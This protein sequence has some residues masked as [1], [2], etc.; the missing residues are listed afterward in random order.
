[1]DSDTQLPLESARRLI[2]TI[3]HP[4]NRVEID[5]VS[6]VRTSG[7]TII[8]PRISIALPA[9]TATRFTRIFADANGTDPYCEAVSDAQQE[10]LSEGIFHGKAIYDVKAFH[11]ILK[12]RFPAETILS[13]DLIEGAHAGVGL[14][15]DIELFENMP[16]DYG[17]FAARERRWIRGD[18]QIAPWMFGNVPLSGGKKCRTPLS[19][20][21]RWRILDNLRR[22]LI[23]VA[24]VGLLL[25]GWLMSSAPAVGSLVV[26]LAV[27][28][29]AFAPLLDRLARRLHGSVRGWHGAADDVRRAAVMIAFLPH[30]AW[31]AID[32]IAR[33]CYRRWFSH[34]KMLEWQT[35]ERVQTLGRQHLDA[36]FRQLLG[37]SILSMVLAVVLMRYGV[38][39]PA[40]LFVGLWIF[41][42]LL[43]NWLASPGQ[44]EPERLPEND[45]WFLRRTAR[46]TWRYF[47][48]PVG[49]ETNWLP[50]DNSQVKYRV[51][52]APRT[53]P[54]NI[55]LWFVAALTAWDFGYLTTDEMIS[56]CAQTIDTVRRLERCDTHLLNW[57]DTRTLLPLEPRYVSTVD[58]GNLVAALWVFAEGCI[59]AMRAPVIGSVAFRGLSDSLAVFRRSMRQR[60]CSISRPA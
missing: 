3:A 10:L 55:G 25:A 20:I 19:A 46:R 33:V 2:E 31:L 57:Y 38:W 40:V 50:P 14:A 36:T 8:Q 12:D 18:W 6:R 5:P 47:N 44:P 29:P 32:S 49:D 48:D 34:R 59:D 58:S 28:I 39:A 37:V 7:Y 22:S 21:G 11:A 13:H 4:L 30:Q 16:T 41:A 1:M 35:A 15:S 23:P 42:P 26:G 54:T 9:A 53:S 43:M 24:A 51:E 56:R 17:S 27:A 52:V 45:I 60:P